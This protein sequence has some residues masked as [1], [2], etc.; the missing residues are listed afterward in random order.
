[1]APSVQW[2]SVA[3]LVDVGKGC[4]G[5]KTVQT[6]AHLDKNSKLTHWT[7]IFK[8]FFLMNAFVAVCMYTLN[9][10]VIFSPILHFQKISSLH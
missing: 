10:M 5:D 1:M 6:S 9:E 4:G 7:R 3:E 2:V 8:S